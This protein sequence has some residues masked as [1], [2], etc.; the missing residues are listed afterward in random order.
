MRILHIYKD[1]YPVLGGIENHVRVLAEAQVRAGHHV[2]VLVAAR[3]PRTLIEEMSG[4]QVIKAGRLATVAS[5]PLS[6]SLPAIV[7]RL[8]P[9][10]THLHFPYPL[11]E[12][13][14]TLLGRARRTV[15]TYHSDI[16]RQQGLLRFYRPLLWRVLAKADRIIATSPN[17]IA[18]SPYLQRFADKCVVIPLGID[19]DRFSAPDPA[20]VAAFRNRI[21]ISADECRSS[22]EGI[23]AKQPPSALLLF[24]GR[25]RYYKGLDDLLRAL[26]QVP[27]HLLVGGSG[28]ME[29]PWRALAQQLGVAER[30]HFLG[31]VPD[32]LLPSLYHA[33]DIF[34][35]PANAR[36]EAFG[37]V[38]LEAMAAG[39]PAISTEVGTGTSYVNRHGETGLVV[40][41]CE[42]G[43]LARAINL[44]LS[45]TDLRRRL[46]EQAR[47]RARRPEFSQAHMVQQVLELYHELLAA[48]LTTSGPANSDVDLV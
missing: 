38:L 31:D 36:A 40:P 33:A 14:H 8:R 48:S 30:V 13:A 7:A 47:M 6:L 28:P 21:P 22:K 11:G 9:D 1:Y 12:A 44:L 17:Y 37:T 15:I 42:P 4:V 19:A 16:V 41:P 34:V 29:Q 3:G 20:Q 27:A 35:L 5:A 26:T 32:E 25:L 39:L 45:D 43:A 10:I 24:V 2:T 23:S 46:G 18:T